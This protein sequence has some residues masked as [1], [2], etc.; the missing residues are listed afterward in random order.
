LAGRVEILPG[1]RW[2]SELEKVIQ[3]T[4]AAAV[5]IGENGFGPWEQPEYEGTLIEFVDRGLPVIPVLLPGAPESPKLPLFLRGFTWVDL[6]SG[7]TKE[8]LDLLVW[9][10]TGRSPQQPTRSLQK[11]DYFKRPYIFIS[12]CRKDEF[13]KNRLVTHLSVLEQENLLEV[14]SD[15]EIGAG[16]EWL[17]EIEQAID[18]SSVAVLLISVDFLASQFIR[19]K[20]FPEF[21]SV[22]PRKV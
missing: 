4:R 6:R 10:I 11:I 20:R 13:W 22:E 3:A 17:K 8:G 5:L 2:I 16:S 19:S 18:K 9:G 1:R 15:Q 14:W 21:L 7:L 12:Y